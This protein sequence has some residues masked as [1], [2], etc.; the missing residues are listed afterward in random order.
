M[1][2]ENLMIIGAGIIVG[3][4]AYKAFHNPMK[5]SKSNFS[6]ACGCGG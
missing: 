3:I 5:K 6:S 1:K 2:K 4:I